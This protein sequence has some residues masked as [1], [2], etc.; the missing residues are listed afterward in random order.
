MKCSGVNLSKLC[1]EETVLYQI[2]SVAWVLVG[3]GEPRL[4]LVT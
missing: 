4:P 1:S 2:M 3:P